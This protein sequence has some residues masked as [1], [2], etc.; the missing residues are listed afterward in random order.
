MVVCGA[1]W[2]LAYGSC[3][4]FSWAK[5]SFLAIQLVHS[6]VS[7]QQG[8]RLLLT[9]KVHKPLTVMDSRGKSLLELWGI[10]FLPDWQL[11]LTFV[12]FTSKSHEHVLVILLE[13]M[14]KNFEMNRTKIKGGC[15]SG[16]K[17][18]TRNSKCDSPLV[19][20]FFLRCILGTMEN[21]IV[22]WRDKH[23]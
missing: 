23:N 3:R 10:T 1:G 16:R 7:S 20:W 4:H 5:Q 9:I 22:L 6:G 14:H 8:T 19:W 2:W 15:Q 11:P 18:V 12:W 13:P 17:V 21:I